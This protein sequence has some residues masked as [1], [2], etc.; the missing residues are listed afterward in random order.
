MKSIN[1]KITNLECSSCAMIIDFDLEELEGVKE[2]STNYAK[3]R[4]TVLFDQTLIDQKTIIARLK[5]L[6]YEV[7][8]I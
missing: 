2:V 3:Q 4:T 7:K 5:K 8:I 6:N 1:L